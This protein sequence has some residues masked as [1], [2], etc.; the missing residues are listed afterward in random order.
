MWG[1]YCP[2]SSRP[3]TPPTGIRTGK[4]TSLSHS[5][6]IL[7]YLWWCSRV[8]SQ[9]DCSKPERFD[10]LALALLSD[11]INVLLAK[12]K[13]AAPI[14]SR[15]KLEGR[16]CFVLFRCWIDVVQNWRDIFFYQ[17]KKI[18]VC[19]NQRVSQTVL[20]KARLPFSLAFISLR[21]RFSFF[22]WIHVMDS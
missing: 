18:T 15:S 12:A 2:G 6:C 3:H 17:H 16:A 19:L 1:G 9:T 21:W 5:L 14:D 8:E 10:E 22:L 20:C 7:P 13:N 11:T 4:S